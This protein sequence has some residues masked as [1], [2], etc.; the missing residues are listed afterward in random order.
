MKKIFLIVL[1]ASSLLMSTLPVSYASDCPSVKT[2]IYASNSE[3]SGILPYAD[4]IVYKYR[5]LDGK[6]Q[7]RRWNQTR[8]YW[9]D[10][11][12]IDL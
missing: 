5:L 8:G 3:G 9:V 12:W 11:Y 2:P 7:Y 1:L 4:V 10:P 6:Q